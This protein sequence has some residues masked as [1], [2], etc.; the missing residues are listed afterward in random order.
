M[1]MVFLKIKL[2]V[3]LGKRLNFPLL[4]ILLSIWRW[5]NCLTSLYIC[6]LICK[7]VITVIA[8][9]MVLLRS[10]WIG[11][12]STAK[13]LW[14]GPGTSHTVS[15]VYVFISENVEITLGG[16]QVRWLR[17]NCFGISPS[18]FWYIL[19][20]ERKRKVT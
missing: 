14:R 16:S 19:K 2:P 10:K 3:L 6:V 7:L 13:V 12:V 17:R 8:T 1:H 9:P 18:K 15:T 20:V 11:W 5:V 4:E